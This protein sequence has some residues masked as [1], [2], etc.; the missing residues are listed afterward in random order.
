MFAIIAPSCSPYGFG[1]SFWPF[2]PRLSFPGLWKWAVTLEGEIFAL[3]PNLSFILR[4]SN[5]LS[6][7]KIEVIRLRAK[8][9]SGKSDS[10]ECV[11]FKKSRSNG[12]KKTLA[13][14][15]PCRRWFRKFKKACWAFT[16]LSRSHRILTKFWFPES[17]DF[18]LSNG[19]K[20]VKIL[21]G[22]TW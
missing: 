1:A 10:R 5:I 12:D 15:S 14:I 6:L 8:K 20:V 21:Y 2:S 18:D 22:L 13:A 7:P 11:K 16:Y 4:D 19:A 9:G 17:W 3:N